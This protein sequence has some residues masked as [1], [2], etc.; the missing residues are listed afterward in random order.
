MFGFC[1]THIL[2]TGCAKFWKK[3]SV[4]KRLTRRKYCW[5]CVVSG[6][7][8]VGTYRGCRSGRD[9]ARISGW[10]WQFGRL[11]SHVNDPR[12]SEYSSL[13]YTEEELNKK[14]WTGED[15]SRPCGAGV[16]LD[17][18]MSEEGLPVSKTGRYP[19]GERIVYQ[20]RVATGP[21]SSLS[22]PS[23]RGWPFLVIS[24]H[25]MCFSTGTVRV[26]LVITSNTIYM[27]AISSYDH[28][29]H[30]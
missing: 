20:I 1:I 19:R 9:G 18:T 11:F 23:C 16:R 4:A 15:R 29:I 12:R 5:Y 24:H 8:P 28:E 3:K 26:T 30:V 27:L 21:E 25:E 14:A 13:L 10:V 22:R 17:R 2:N 7:A 6:V